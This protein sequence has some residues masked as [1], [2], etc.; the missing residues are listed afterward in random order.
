MNILHLLLNEMRTFRVNGSNGDQIESVKISDEIFDTL[1]LTW[2][3][4][5]TQEKI[6]GGSR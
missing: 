5:R 1:N 2:K 3:Q 6:S 4:W